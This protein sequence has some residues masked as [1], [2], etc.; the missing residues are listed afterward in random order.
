MNN[1]YEELKK[2]LVETAKKAYR[3]KLMAGTSGNM[4]IFCQEQGHII[5]TPSS[6]DYEIME[7]KDAVI[8]DLDG[9]VIE[10][11]HKPSSEWRMHAEIYRQLP[12]VK[13]IVHTH[14]PYAASFAVL[15]REIPVIL[16]EM[17]PFLKGSVEVSSYAAQGS[18]QVGLNAVPVLKRKNA[19][20]MANHGA[21]TV[22]TSLDEA[23]INSV[24]LEDAAKIY[25]MACSVGVPVVIEE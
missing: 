23:Y 16:I 10:G 1:Q 3:E 22:G 9:T 13:A 15:H 7:E 25:H 4:S 14:S 18:A 21:V 8:I 19:C 2:Q 24:Y 17:I 11:I 5:I 12:H 20:L 6:Y